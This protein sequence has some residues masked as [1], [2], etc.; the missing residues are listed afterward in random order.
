M[1]VQHTIDLRLQPVEPPVG[2]CLQTLDDLRERNVARGADGPPQR[3]LVGEVPDDCGET[4]HAR[5][6]I[7]EQCFAGAKPNMPRP[8]NGADRRM[9]QLL[10]KASYYVPAGGVR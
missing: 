8:L 2:T 4:S 10:H 9:S 7:T 6:M 3:P 5:P 1:L